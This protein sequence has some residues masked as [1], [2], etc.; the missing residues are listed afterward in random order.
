MERDF[1]RWD[2]HAYI[3][4]SRFVEG[5][6]IFFTSNTLTERNRKRHA[7]R[8]RILAKAFNDSLLRSAEPRLVGKIQLISDIFGGKLPVVKDQ[9][10]KD[11]SFNMSRWMSFLLWDIMADLSFGGQTNLLTSRENRNIVNHLRNS[12]IFG[13][14]VGTTFHLC[15]M[16]ALFD[17]QLLSESSKATA[18]TSTGRFSPI[19]HSHKDLSPESNSSCFA[20]AWYG[21]A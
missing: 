14:L 8:R 16:K 2:R 17:S 1:E 20:R 6:E 19:S 3:T 15:L 9:S 18:D 11:G 5:S 13:A 10:D 7:K 4:K 12:T 21:R